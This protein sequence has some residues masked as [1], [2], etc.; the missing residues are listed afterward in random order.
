MLM[1]VIPERYKQEL[2][3]DDSNVSKMSYTQY[4]L[5]RYIA[6]AGMACHPAGFCQRPISK[7]CVKAFSQKNYPIWI[8]LPIGLQYCKRLEGKQT[9]SVNITQ[10]ESYKYF[11]RMNIFVEHR[12]REKRF[13]P[14][15]VSL[16][17]SVSSGHSLS[18]SLYKSLHGC[19]QMA[20][21]REVWEVGL[22]QVGGGGRQWWIY[23][24][25]KG[26]P[27]PYIY[28]IGSNRTSN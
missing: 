12:N 21:F 16:L 14:S 19:L 25:T 28:A 10:K 5:N 9:P 1:K 17:Q 24:F 13:S 15:W 26:E 27:F 20:L 4:M 22:G 18:F 7:G 2:I 11:D 8:R 3:I 6:S 23:C